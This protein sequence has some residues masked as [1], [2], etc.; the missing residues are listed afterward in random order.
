M[1]FVRLQRVKERI[2]TTCYTVVVYLSAY[3]FIFLLF[4]IVFP[5]IQFQNYLRILR[6][7]EQGEEFREMIRE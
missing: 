7:A 1:A 6:F 4:V 2:A 3:S 5:N